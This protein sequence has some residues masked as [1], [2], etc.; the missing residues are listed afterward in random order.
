MPSGICSVGGTCTWPSR[1]PFAAAGAGVGGIAPV[2]SLPPIGATVGGLAPCVIV[3]CELSSIE[4][5]G[6][7]GTDELFDCRPSGVGEVI[8]GAPGTGACMA[9]AALVSAGESEEAGSSIAGIG[10]AELV[11]S[12]FIAILKVPSTIT[13]TLAPTS[14][15][16]IFEVMLEPSVPGMPAAGLGLSFALSLAFSADAALA[17]DLAE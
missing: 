5:S 10:G 4:L 9:G 8:A 12:R 1:P 17:A 3:I 7:L 16:R 15:E 13:T 6:M 2:I 11:S 14:S